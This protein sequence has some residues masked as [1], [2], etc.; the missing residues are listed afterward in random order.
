MKR[1]LKITLILLF[2]IYNYCLGQQRYTSIKIEP[3]AYQFS[4]DKDQA[5]T[6]SYLE[7]D[8]KNNELWRSVKYPKEHIEIFDT[9]TGKLKRKILPE[10][11]KCNVFKK[12]EDGNVW[13]QDEDFGFKLIN[14]NGR[15]L[16][17]LQE[18]G[19][20]RKYGADMIACNS[21]FCPISVYDNMV[22]TTGYI[23]LLPKKDYAI[24]N[25]SKWGTLRGIEMNEKVRYYGSIP[26]ASAKSFYG[27]LNSFASTE[28]NGKIVVAPMFSNDIQVIDVEKRTAKMFHASTKYDKLIKPLGKLEDYRSYSID[29]AN[30]HFVSNYAFIGIVYDKY[31]DVYYRFIRHPGNSIPMRCSIVVMDKNFRA[32]FYYDVPFDYSPGRFFIDKKGLLLANNNNYLKDNNKLTFDRLSL[33]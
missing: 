18:P 32:L 1:S 22:L 28:N 16:K 19:V 20:G 2:P 13:I 21:S 26:K 3:K 12:M 14:K 10:G 7:F 6:S 33:L 8:E 24:D 31:R 11:N 9:K 17:K 25:Y 23:I 30:K 27:G 4:L 29:Q 15:I 5:L